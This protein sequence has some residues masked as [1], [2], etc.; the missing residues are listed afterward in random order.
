MAAL[1]I[2]H[3]GHWYVSL[4]IFMGPVVLLF[5]WVYLGDWLDKRKSRD[6]HESD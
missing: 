1:P 4:P 2:A 6:E 5:G 3:I